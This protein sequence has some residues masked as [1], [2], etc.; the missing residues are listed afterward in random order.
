MAVVD[1]RSDTVTRPTE[2]MRKAMFE[3]EV[4]DD[5]LGDDPTVQKL[6]ALAAEKMRKEAALYVPSGTMGNSV[7]IKTWTNPGDEVILD[8][9][10]HIVNYESGHTGFVSGVQIRTL[11]NISGHIQP[12]HV[13]AA[14]RPKSL[15]LPNTNLICLE[16]TNNHAGGRVMPFEVMKEIRAIA[17]EHGLRVHLDG[18]RI[19]NASV[20]TGIPVKEMAALADSVMFCL[21][22]GLCAP[23]GSML[24]GPQDF[25]ERAR[26]VRK[27][28]GGGMRQAG[29]LAAPGIVALT[30]MTERLA[31]DH[32]RAKKLSQAIADLPGIVL[33]ADEV[34]TN[35]IIFGLDHPKHGIFDLLDKLRE[36]DVWALPR[37]NDAIRLVTHHDVDDQG[38]DHAIASFGKVLVN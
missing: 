7:A 30:R 27:I 26:K 6:E 5:V 35:I 38:I 1:L 32:D 24:V 3:A 12:S 15:H 22:K 28:L 13:R 8:E 36:Y 33:N 2:E 14:I 18:A 19:F 17:D 37:G 4:G 31:D 9:L 23:V 20:A 11:P 34:E 21:S 10:A 29:V 25:I 16:N